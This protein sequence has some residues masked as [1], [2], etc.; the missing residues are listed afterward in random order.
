[1]KRGR[2]VL[3]VIVLI[4]SSLYGSGQSFA[5][6]SAVDTVSQTGFYSITLSLEWLAYL[7]SDLSDIRIRDGQGGAVPFL[8]RPHQ[9]E[10]RRRLINF[11][12]L[13]NSTDST[14][15]TLELDAGAYQGTD[16]LYL[17][18]GNTAVERYASLSGSNNGTQWF[19]IDENL[20]LQ[21]GADDNNDQ[22]VQLLRFPFIRYR[23]L[24][25]R[26]DNSRTDPLMVSEAGTY[27]DTAIK[28]YAGLPLQPPTTY[29]QKDSSDG[30][31]YIWAHTKL[32]YPVESVLLK[33]SG[34]K[35]YI[36]EIAVYKGVTQNGALLAS[37]K[38]RTAE[39]AFIELPG[40][41]TAD[42]LMTIRN[43]ENP[44]VVVTALS[45]QCSRRELI[46]YLEKDKSYI[47]VGGNGSVQPPDYDLKNFQ[48]SIP[49]R[50]VQLAL[51]RV[52]PNDP[53]E[54]GPVPKTQWWIWLSV[55]VMLAVLSGLTLRLLGEMNKEKKGGN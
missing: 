55:A 10:Q 29:R 35:Y 11:P 20:L 1:M 7:K 54:A 19:I 36:R 26:I 18:I 30:Y 52:T 24:K 34:P 28:P 42:L 22:F 9:I 16:R 14:A 15:T 37:A 3:A 25:L 40:A 6:K 49:P 13:K 43:G 2:R 39:E 8:I 44:P 46:A 38:I 5:W 51:G 23:Y 45:T 27:A 4:L 41:K 48:D 12:V 21:N 50:M 33:L 17:L 47:L 53:S 32:P 31:T